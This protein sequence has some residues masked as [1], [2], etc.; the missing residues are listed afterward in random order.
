METRIEILLYYYVL[1]VLLLATAVFNSTIS[2]SFC[3][4][5]GVGVTMS[6]MSRV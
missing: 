1:I 2:S 4:V 6:R 5:D 3:G